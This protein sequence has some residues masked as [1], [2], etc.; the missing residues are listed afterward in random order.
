MVAILAQPAHQLQRQPSPAEFELILDTHLCRVNFDP[1]G[2]R[3]V[4]VIEELELRVAR[5]LPALRGPLDA[6]ALGL[7]EFAEPSDRSLTRPALRS[8]R[9]DQCPVRLAFSLDLSVA[10]PDEHAPIIGTE[11]TPS[12]SDISTT[13]RFARFQPNRSPRIDAAS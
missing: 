1:L 11:I 3:V 5:L 6:G 13:T 8:V 12:N 10:W 9:L 7:L 2:L 4:V